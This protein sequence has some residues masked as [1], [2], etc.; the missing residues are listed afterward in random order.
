MMPAAS[1]WM[2]PPSRRHAPLNPTHRRERDPEKK[3]TARRK[4]TM[5]VMT[6]VRR[7]IPPVRGVDEE[8]ALGLTHRTGE[9]QP[10][11]GAAQ[12]RVQRAPFRRTERQ[13]PV[14]RTI[15]DPPGLLRNRYVSRERLRF[16]LRHRPHRAHCNRFEASD[17]TKSRKP[18]PTP[19]DRH[20]R[21]RERHDRQ[22]HRASRADPAP[23]SRSPPPTTV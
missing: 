12:P 21:K 8:A 1:Q 6:D 4:K 7:G 10:V 23:W 11:I 13:Q 17:H 3:D 15:E 22:D 16:G 14:T 20:S 18:A 9:A 19:R 5:I 2:H